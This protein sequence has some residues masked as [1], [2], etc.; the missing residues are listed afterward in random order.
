MMDSTSR[1]SH[2]SS[3]APEIRGAMPGSPPRPPFS[4]LTLTVYSL[5]GEDMF[6]IYVGPDEVHF[7]VHKRVLCDRVPCFKMFGGDFEE[8]VENVARFP[9]DDPDSFDMLVDWIYFY[10][11]RALGT[12]KGPDGED[13]TTWD[14]VKFYRLAEKFCLPI[15]QDC[16]M[17]TVI[18]HHKKTQT[19]PSLQFIDDTWEMTSDNSPLRQYVL[20]SLRY[21]ERNLN[22]ED[23]EQGW[24]AAGIQDL[25]MVSRATE[26]PSLLLIVSRFLK[27]LLLLRECHF[28]LP[29]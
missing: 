1:K 28:E 20:Q 24:P 3:I 26:Q 6:D 12:L 4:F 10:N 17:D 16:I 7:R 27:L 19:F 15:V 14:P 11:V 23:S 9:V 2:Y 5:Y 8:G 22:K 18:K 25:W 29:S 21:I 13:I